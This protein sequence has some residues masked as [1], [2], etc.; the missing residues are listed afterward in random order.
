MTPSP[1]MLADKT[2]SPMSLSS[3]EGFKTQMLALF[4]SDNPAVEGSPLWAL[5]HRKRWGRGRL[6]GWEVS[7]HSW[8]L[9]GGWLRGQEGQTHRSNQARTCV[10]AFPPAG[11]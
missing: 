1:P 10:S 2:P 7:K 3:E 5:L 8:W 11:Q 4:V 6:A 9:P